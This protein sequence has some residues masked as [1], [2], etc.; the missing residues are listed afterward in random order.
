MEPEWWKCFVSITLVNRATLIVIYVII[1]LTVST[2]YYIRLAL[3]LT[4]LMFL[5][6]VAIMIWIWGWHDISSSISSLTPEIHL[7]DGD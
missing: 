2:E 6:S 1:V 4:Q 3:F 7:L 5:I